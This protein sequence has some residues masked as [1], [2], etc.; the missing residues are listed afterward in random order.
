MTDRNPAFADRVRQ[1]FYAGQMESRLQLAV[2]N[3]LPE[4]PRIR[5]TVHLLKLSVH[6]GEA[7]ALHRV[8]KRVVKAMA[9]SRASGNAKSTDFAR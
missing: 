9:A 6:A 2:S 7:G 3:P 1:H 8:G 4:Y 5:F